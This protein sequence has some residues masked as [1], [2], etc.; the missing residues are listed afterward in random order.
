[1]SH[2]WPRVPIPVVISVGLFLTLWTSSTASF[3]FIQI[4]SPVSVSAIKTDPP[5]IA[6]HEVEKQKG[7]DPWLALNRPANETLSTELELEPLTVTRFAD[8]EKDEE[9]E[10]TRVVSSEAPLTLEGLEL[11]RRDE[12]WIQELPP[13]QQKH[14][15]QAQ[16]KSDLLGEDWSVPDF[17]EELGKILEEEKIPSRAEKHL[18]SRVIVQGENGETLSE[19]K[20]EFDPRAREI[21]LAGRLEILG[22]PFTNDTYF[23]IRRRVN[24]IELE[25]GQVDIEKG[26][27]QIR[28]QGQNGE[29]IA[30][31]RDQSGRILG[32]ARVSLAQ[33]KKTA[34][35]TQGPLLSLLPRAD[36]AGRFSDLYQAGTTT[37]P[38]STVAKV[39]GDAVESQ[40]SRQGDFEV[41][42]VE[43]G[44][45][46]L[47]RL[48][49]PRHIPMTTILLA[50]AR[51]EL[52]LLPGSMVSALK[53][54]VSEQRQVN[55]QDPQAPVIWGRVLLDEKPVAGIQVELENHPGLQAV[56]FND[57]LLPDMNLK[58]TSRNGLYAFLSPP[59]G[60]QA[61]VAK[62]NEQLFGHVN[63]VVEKGSVASGEIRNSLRTESKP[64]FVY[65]A[66]SGEP[67][68]AEVLHQGLEELFFVESSGQAL[69][70]IPEVQRHSLV[71]VR[72]D[73]PYAP[74]MTAVD[75]FAGQLQ[76]PLVRED[77]L[78]QIKAAAR[79][80][81]ASLGAIIVGFVP[82]ED[83]K[84]ELLNP[85]GQ[86]RLFHFDS[87]GGVFEGQAGKAGGGFVI[88]NV[89]PGT[90]EV[91]VEGLQSGRLSSRLLPLE[92][93]EVGVLLFKAD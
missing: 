17:R 86:E 73:A 81:D 29:L 24:G 67:R 20:V 76:L 51:P 38:K 15:A 49:S 13:Q 57:L 68:A 25:Q 8:E 37:W 47:F 34:G 84:A 55:L 7:D 18:P 21:D 26:E 79:L 6:H 59:E 28:L 89:S 74:A 22:L 83:F 45:H 88:F 1:M 71:Q 9:N 46:S 50:G 40:V 66:F 53:S 91:V 64:V 87:V 77:W 58:T 62:K 72:P 80:D 82:E 4:T 54:L 36:Y 48:D 39:F 61:L 63:V 93:N 70:L 31:Q 92:S 75:D 10:V 33:V 65:D 78:L 23:E 19:A 44:S 60:F 41:P 90:R 16:E 5:F 35:L 32:Q 43:A 11:S 69:A 42:G 30:R 85:T 2:E 3:R 14:L 52:Q 56:Y 12:S 27:Y